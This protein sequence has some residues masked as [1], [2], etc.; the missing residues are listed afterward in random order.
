V[1]LGLPL[2]LGIARAHGG[3]LGAAFAPGGGLA[4]TLTLPLA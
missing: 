1:G 4:F 3:D 2:C